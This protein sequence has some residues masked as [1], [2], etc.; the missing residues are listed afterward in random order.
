M[1]GEMLY[2]TFYQNM[3]GEM[4]YITFYQ[5]MFGEML[6][7]TFYQNMF[8][9]QIWSYVIYNISPNMFYVKHI[10]STQLALEIVKNP[11]NWLGYFYSLT[12]RRSST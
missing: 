11:P 12:R 10:F 6:Y 9:K 5:N 4:L 7:I 2:I 1:F 8:A 3:F